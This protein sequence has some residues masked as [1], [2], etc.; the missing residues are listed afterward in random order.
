MKQLLIFLFVCQFYNALSDDLCWKTFEEDTTDADVIFVGR[1]IDI[2]K[3]SYWIRNSPTHVITFRVMES[4]KGISKYNQIF[5][6]LS[7]VH[8]CCS[9]RFVEDSTF[10]VFAY[11]FGQSSDAYW[12]NDCS[13]TELLSEST[14]AYKR[15]GI[16]YKPF[17]NRRNLDLFTELKELKTEKHRAKMD[18][19]NLILSNLELDVSNERRQ[20]NGFMISLVV[21]L[22]VFMLFVYK[23]K[24]NS[25]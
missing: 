21:F 25:R 3:R 15:L 12:T 18:S 6:I 23:R 1:V 19:I 10:L 24:I 8:G 5:S 9:P 13:W 7:P 11:G 2:N 4:F 17:Y 20:K 22:I 16:P 14:E